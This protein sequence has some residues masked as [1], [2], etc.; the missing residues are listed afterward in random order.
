MN[1]LREFLHLDMI[2]RLGHKMFATLALAA[3]L[4]TLFNFNVSAASEATNSWLFPFGNEHFS[5][6]NPSS[7]PGLVYASESDETETEEDSEED[8]DDRNEDLNDVV[9]FSQQ[10]EFHFSTLLTVFGDQSLPGV[11]C[12]TKKRDTYPSVFLLLENFR[13]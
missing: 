9:F 4:S 5:K 10:P 1:S 6:E 13:L 11:V 7:V 8:T 2:K 12:Y 3:I